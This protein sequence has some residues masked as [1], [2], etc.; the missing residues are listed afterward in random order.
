M[1]KEA[2][3]IMLYVLLALL[4]LMWGGSF[5]FIKILLQDFGPWEVTFF[6][7]ALGALTLIVLIAA[8]PAWRAGLSRRTPW[9][10]IALIG[11]LNA[12]IPW[13]LIAFS[14]MRISSITA[15]IT[16]ATTPLWTLIAGIVLFGL[17]PLRSQWIGLAAGFVG[18]VILIRP[19]DASFLNGDALGIAGMLS[20]T[21]CYGISSQLMQHRLRGVSAYVMSLVTLAAGALLSGGMSLAYGPVQWGAILDRETLPALIG[22]GVFGSGVS[23]VLFY[24]IIKKAGAE[25]ATLVTYLLP[26]SA[27]MWGYFLLDEEITLFSLLGLIFILFGVFLSGGKQ[28]A[29][30][31]ESV[32]PSPEQGKAVQGVHTTEP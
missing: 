2:A 19:T 30:A 9:L 12:C 15:S 26:P 7:S 11:L 20:A 10:T 24:T 28:R 14:E 6:R 16:N 32:R 22:L 27:M 8:V 5:Y 29:D 3:V 23:Y 4:G 17:R 21:L 1:G 31:E 13:A 25:F 18:V